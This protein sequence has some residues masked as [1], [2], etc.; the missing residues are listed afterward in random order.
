MVECEVVKASPAKKIKLLKED[1][2]VE[3]FSD[4]QINQMLNFY[5]RN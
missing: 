4:E 1:V 2:K 5:R 3:V